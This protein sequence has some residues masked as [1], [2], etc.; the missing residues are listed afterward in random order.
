MEGGE[1][2]QLHSLAPSGTL[3]SCSPSVVYLLF[4]IKLWNTFLT[5]PS[6]PFSQL[7]QGQQ[8]LLLHV[9]RASWASHAAWTRRG[10]PS[11]VA[12]R[13]SY[14]VQ[15]LA[16]FLHPCRSLPRAAHQCRL[17]VTAPP[18]FCFAGSLPGVAEGT[19]LELTCHRK[20]GN[21]NNQNHNPFQTSQVKST[22]TSHESS[23]LPQFY[24]ADSI[25]PIL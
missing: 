20:S 16:G 21:I 2:Y 7:A 23:F 10:H 1:K 15:P 5:V 19:A 17:S 18:L 22:L 13:G 3:S 24:K 11:W 8:A 4:L 6:C 14:T 12:P 9:P 25:T